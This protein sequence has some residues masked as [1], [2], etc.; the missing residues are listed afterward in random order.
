VAGL[1]IGRCHGL[2]DRLMVVVVLKLPAERAS[3]APPQTDE[4]CSRAERP[5]GSRRPEAER[6]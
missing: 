3:E 1:W 2:T 6:V 5:V 4:A